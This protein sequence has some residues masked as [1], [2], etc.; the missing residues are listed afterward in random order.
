MGN[1]YEKLEAG[2]LKQT[3]KIYLSLHPLKQGKTEF[4]RFFCEDC[5]LI[6]LLFLNRSYSAFFSYVSSIAVS[7]LEHDVRIIYK[8]RKRKT[9]DTEHKVS[10]LTADLIYLG[11]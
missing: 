6:A 3:K 11:V 4:K 2:L 1:P 9:A 5:K 10:F 7:T 8:N